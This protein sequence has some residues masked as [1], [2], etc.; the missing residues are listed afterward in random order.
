MMPKP[1]WLLA[2]ML[3][4]CLFASAQVR[5]SGTVY[6]MN[7]IFPLASVSVLTHSGKGTI[8][9]SLGRYSIV[10]DERDSIY[11]SYLGK[12]TPKYAVNTITTPSQFDISLHVNI[13]TLREVSVMPRNYKMDSIQN[14]KDYAKVFDFKK[15][16][17][18]FSS[19]PPASGNFGVGFD[20]DELINVFRFRRNRSMLAFQE[21]LILEEQDKF[22]AQRFTKPKV[23]KITGLVGND[24]DSF[25][26]YYRPPYEFAVY[27]SEYEFLEY[28]KKAGLEYQRIKALGG[29][30]GARKEELFEPF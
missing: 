11:F 12:A 19:S 1:I 29:R 8:T 10:V 24:L 6:E 5:V 7:R 13:T 27:A 18:G 2:L 26:Y 22:V 21:R 20:L 25:M 9:D 17:I 28:I 30:L 3:F 23:R 14:R 16:G 15:P 4:S